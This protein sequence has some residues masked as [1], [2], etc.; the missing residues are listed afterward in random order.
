MQ[1]I[2]RLKKQQETLKEERKRIKKDLKN[3]ERR[4]SRIRKKAK[5]LSDSDL[6]HVLKMRGLGGPD[7][8]D[9]RA[10]EG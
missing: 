5:Q 9:A 10:Q 6:M 3:A 1:A 4:R 7:E 8:K 2:T